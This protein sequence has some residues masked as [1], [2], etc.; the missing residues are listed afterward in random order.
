MLSRRALLLG[1]AGA[2]VAGVGAVGVGIQ[3]GV[4]P[5]RPFLQEL[6]GRNGEDGFVP[7]IAP[8]R[9]ERGSFPSQHR[10]GVGTGWA[11]CRPPGSSG[12]LPLVVAL[13]G[14]G[15]DH[16]TLIGPSFGLPEFLAQAVAG[17]VPPFA[18]AT[19]D[20]GTSYWHE[21]PSGEDAGTMI[22]DEL[23]PLLSE[24]G[25]LTDRIGLMGWSMGGYGALRLGSLL[26]PDRVAAVC[27]VSP[28][29]WT[30]ATDAS[31]S[32]FANAEEYDEFRVTGRQGDL[33]GIPV[34][35]DCGTGDPFYR[36]VEDYVAGFPSSADLT[37]T[38][39]PGRHQAGY[40][41]RMLP[42]ELEFVGRRLTP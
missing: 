25:V 13:H 12:P 15:G 17:G 42:V 22:I 4:L 32:G 7:D 29:L 16:A 19:V 11:L 18:I 14:V 26:G 9:V 39:Q 35:I 6:L 24:R 40:W 10:L 5:G 36:A 1:T 21:R 2:G 23:L 28:A 8:G 38:F 37:S 34:R 27:A 33:A 20:G 31:R 3:Q 30:D 41:R